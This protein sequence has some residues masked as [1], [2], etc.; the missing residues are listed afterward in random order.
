MNQPKVTVGLYRHFKGGYFYV[1]GFSKSALDE[2]TPMVNY[3][4]VCYPEHGGFVRP[5]NNFTASF[6]IDPILNEIKYIKDREDNVTGQHHR[7]ERVKDLNFQLGS[8]S[9]EQLIEELRT[10]TDSPIHGLDIEALH[11]K[12]FAKDYIIG[13]AFEQTEDFPQ[14]VSTLAVFST[15]EKAK[16]F[17]ENH[18][19][20]YRTKVFKRTFIEVE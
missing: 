5:L 20:N 2:S 1:T 3:F 10:R 8:V 7:F 14:G 18:G 13:E 17:F 19:F 16:Q 11:S 12:V 15:E 6:E 9:T 4:N